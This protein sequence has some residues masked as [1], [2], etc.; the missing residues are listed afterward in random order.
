MSEWIRAQIMGNLLK[1]PRYCHTSKRNKFQ[2]KG[3]LEIMSEWKFYFKS[4][5]FIKSKKKN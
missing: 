3:W 5:H 4:E 1:Q 2:F